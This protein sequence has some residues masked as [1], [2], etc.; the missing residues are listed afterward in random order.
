MVESSFLKQSVLKL[1]L[2]SIILENG[3]VTSSLTHKVEPRIVQVRK[4]KFLSSHHLNSRARIDHDW[5]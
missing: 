1:T 3:R 2:F 5:R 4:R